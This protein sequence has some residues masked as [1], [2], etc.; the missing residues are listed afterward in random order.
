M[1]TRER[2]IVDK[3]RGTIKRYERMIQHRLE[4]ASKYREIAMG[5]SI[6][7][8]SDGSKKSGMSKD[9][10]CDCIASVVDL[11]HDADKLIDAKYN[12]LQMIENIEGDNGDYL[13]YRY[14]EDL[15]IKEICKKMGYCERNIYKIREKALDEF[16]ERYKDDI[17]KSVH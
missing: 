15:G 1:I 16:Y 4:S 13:F 7:Y 3:Y 17:Q 6:N 14:V 8:D 11:E 12:K 2:R 5:T 10:L 9:K